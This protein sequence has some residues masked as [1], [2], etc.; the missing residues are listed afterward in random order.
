MGTRESS[1][2]ATTRYAHLLSP[3][4]LGFITLRNRVVMGSMHTGMEDSAGAFGKLAA[5]LAERARGGVGLIVTGGIAPNLVGT[6]RLR[7]GRLSSAGAIARHGII[8]R[9]VHEAGA[10]ICMQILHTGRYARH[11][12]AVAPSSVRSPIRRRLPRALSARGVERQIDAFARCAVLAREAGYDGVELMGS[13]GYL[14]NQFLVARCNRRTDEWGGSFSNRAEF[15]LQIAQRVR[16]A[17]GRDFLLIFRLSMLDLV[18]EGGNLTESI[19]LANRLCS[20]GVDLINT[21]IGWHEASVPTIAG[22][23][24]RGAFSWVTARVRERIRVPII[25]SNRINDP[26]VAERI[27]VSGHADLISMARP[28]LADPEIVRKLTEGRSEDIN[29]CIACNQ[30]CLDRVLEGRRASC[31]VNPR[32]CREVELR[33]RS[34]KRRRRIAVVGAGPAG[35]ACAVTA[36]ERGHEVHLYEATSQIGGQFTLA[37]RI[38]G[39]QEFGETLRYFSRRIAQTGVRLRLG[40]RA[41]ADELLAGAFDQVVLATGVHPR[42]PEIQG[43]KHPKVVSYPEAIRHPERLERSVAIIGA[44]GIAIDVAMLLS[45]PP[46][47]ADAGEIDAFLEEWGVDPAIESP[48]GLRKRV[49]GPVPA[50]RVW[51]LQRGTL[52]LGAHLGR[53]TMWIHRETLRRRGVSALQAVEYRRI[54]DLGLHIKVDGRD[55]LLP[56]Q[57][58]VIC[59]GQ[60]AE[61]E[62]AAQLRQRHVEPYL[63]GGARSVHRLDAE[64]AIYEGTRLALSL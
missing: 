14:I 9:S 31:L 8:T 19:W 10:R 1:S 32:A 27:L 33:V 36:A 63:I 46:R 34:A 51:I 50:G 37:R 39:K 11:F 48:G 18:S 40:Q 6:G 25:A 57:H 62:L 3:L 45:A 12:M 17:V 23:V 5:F 58:V 30:S 16:A 2:A 59:A 26:D 55:S 4:H 7:A 61:C 29:T 38:P 20:A 54:D 22:V 52:G 28:L 56:V 15:A 44:G 35:L 53:S 60:E 24:P 43:I 49:A 64:R 21:G 47:R 42:L 13:E 41:C